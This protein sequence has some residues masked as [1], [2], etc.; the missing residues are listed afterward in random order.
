MTKEREIELLT[1]IEE[2]EC[3]LRLIH[4]VTISNEVPDLQI[5]AELRQ[6][7]SLQFC[8]CGTP[9]VFNGGHRCELFTK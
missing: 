5:A 2:L 9:I 1:R 6:P 3:A 7:I 4:D 8:Q